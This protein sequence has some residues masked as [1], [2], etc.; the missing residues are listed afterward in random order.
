MDKARRKELIAAQKAE[1]QKI[2]LLPHETGA[3]TAQMPAEYI[4][5]A[6][7]LDGVVQEQNKVLALAQQQYDDYLD[8]S[9]Q[10]LGIQKPYSFDRAKAEFT[11]VR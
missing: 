5:I 10:L 9:A 1:L 6:A 11:E 2:G 7:V 3:R 8:Q 4:R